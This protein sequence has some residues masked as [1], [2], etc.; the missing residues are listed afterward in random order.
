MLLESQLVIELWVEKEKLMGGKGLKIQE[1][2]QYL[3]G[4]QERCVWFSKGRGSCRM[5]KGLLC[6]LGEEGV[7]VGKE[8][9]VP[10]LPCK[11]FR[12]HLHLILWRRKLKSREVK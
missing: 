4:S 8:G 5:K 2:G 1:K 11:S 10:I 3:D 6:L 7:M 9:M 12:P